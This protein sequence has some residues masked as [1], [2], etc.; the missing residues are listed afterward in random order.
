MRGHLRRRL[1]RH[2]AAGRARRPPLPALRGRARLLGRAARG[3]G[4]DR[5]GAAARG[6][7]RDHVGRGRG[8][9]Q[10]PERGRR[11][12]RGR[13][14]DRAPGAAGRPRPGRPG[15]R[16]RG[17]H[18][19][20]DHRQGGRGQGGGVRHR[21]LHP[22]PGAAPELPQRA[23]VRRL[24]GRLQRGRL[25]L[26]RRRPGGPAPQH[27]LR[28]DVPGVAGEGG[29]PRPGHVGDVLGGRRLD[30][31]GRQAG[32]AG[33][34]REA[35]LQ[36]ARPDLLP[37]GPGRRR[38][39][40]PGADGHLGPAQPGPLGQRRVRPADRAPRHR[41]R[42]RG[43]RRRPWPAGRGRRRAARPLRRGHRRPAPGRRLP[44]QP[45]GDAR[46]LQRAG[47]DRQGHRLRA[48]RAGRR[49]AV[50]RRGQGGAGP[51]Q[52]DHVAAVRDRPYYAALV[53]GGTLDTKAGP[54]RHPTARSGRPGPPHPGLYGSA[55]ASPRLVQPT[56]PAGPPSARSLPWPT[57]RPGR[58]PSGRRATSPSASP[59]SWR[60][61]S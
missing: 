8:G 3:Q 60:S 47:R 16:G 20:R 45:P 33:G 36:R 54:R 56:G 31:L 39:P 38:V 13:G 58:P 37:L 32:P 25:R 34:Q 48:G 30:A 5:P 26:H 14:Q 15:G 51:G 6:G 19:R 29:G 46:P 53:T 2:R 23:R 7:Q 42:P 49:A 17:H 4:P 41:R 21:R 12:R 55:T 40:Q 24:R 1:A 11:A 43:P 10:D 44:A 50:Q 35:G 18:R 28:L 9:G 61:P 27:E 57:V 22:R 52:P 59:P